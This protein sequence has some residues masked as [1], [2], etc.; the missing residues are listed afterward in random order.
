MQNPADIIV[1][2]QGVVGLSAAI[3]ME[4]LGFT[5][6]SIDVNP[7]FTK[8][9]P[10]ISR[11][12]AVNNASIELFKNLNIWKHLEENQIS[13][14]KRMQ[15]WEAKNGAKIEFDSRTC[16]SDKLGVMLEEADLK[17][18]LF[19]EA[20]TR[21][22][23]FINNFHVENVIADAEKIVLS[24]SKNESHSAKFLIIAD[25]ANSPLRDKLGVKIT[26]WSYKQN[27]IIANVRTTKPHEKTAYQVFTEDG[28]L[29]FL[30]QNDSFD[31]S[32]V[33]TVPAEKTQ[34]LLED[35]EATFSDKINS[36]FANKLGEITLRSPRHQFPLK[37]RHTQQYYGRRWILMG[38]AAHTIHPLAGLGL[39]VGLAD[40]KTWIS[41]LKRNN[42]AFLSSKVLKSYH[43]QRKHAL[44]QIIAFMQ[45]LHVLFTQ[46]FTIIKKITSLGL[47]IIN[48]LTPLKRLIIQQ[49][50]GNES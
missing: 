27:A 37:M 8:T 48:T 25:G 7:I 33:W 50:S 18:A 9:K 1:V 49:A 16:A 46:K 13:P 32:I 28:P 23:T 45:A 10:D 6:T 39:N 35:S 2:G 42:N 5:V 15:V 40:L 11:I 47:N 31:C 21:T 30:P 38:D 24:N 3:A 29:A 17:Q 4:K 14:Y 34:V 44:W 22:I 36:I 26:T 12:Y 41:E 20:K 43:R 19:T